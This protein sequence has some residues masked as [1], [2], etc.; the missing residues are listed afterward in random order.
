MSM[1]R[2]T[3]YSSKLLPRM[4][5]RG[6]LMLISLSKL[7]TRIILRCYSGWRD[8]LI[9]TTVEKTMMLSLEEKAKI[10]TTFWEETRLELLRSLLLSKYSKMLLKRLLTTR[11]LSPQMSS[12]LER[13][14]KKELLLKLDQQLWSIIKFKVLRMS[15][16]K[17]RWTWTHLRR[18]ETSTLES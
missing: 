10:S 18:R 6:T 2:T 14:L 4:I 9:L 8:T 11:T 17:Q 16:K 5:S 1:L 7:S 15:S 13:S 3:K 12:K